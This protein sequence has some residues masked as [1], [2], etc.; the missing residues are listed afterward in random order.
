MV[1]ENFINECKKS[2]FKNRLGKIELEGYE[3]P[4]TENNYLKKFSINS[5]CYIDGTII[6]S[7][8]ISKLTGELVGLPND[9][10]LIDKTLQVQA[11]LKY[12][13]SSV[14]YVELGKYY[15]EKPKDLITC[16]QSE[17]TA[18]SSLIN[19]IDKKYICN[20]NFN[21]NV[22]VLD[23][24]KDVCS[25]LGL[26]SNCIDFINNEI[27]IFSNPFTNNETNRVVL[28]TIAIISCSFVT[29]DELTGE[30]CL[31]WLSENEEPDYIFELKD[32]STLEGGNNVFGPVNSLILKNSQINDEN[33]SIQDDESIN[34]NG[35]YPITISEDY[36]LY[37]SELRESA[38][39][40]IFNRLKGLKYV[41]YKLLSYYGKPFLKIGNKVRV[42]QDNEN[43]FDSYIFEHTFTYDGTFE[44]T[45][46]SSILTQQEIKTKQDVSLGQA[47]RNTQIEVNKQEGKIKSTIEEVNNNSSK[48][49]QV[50]QDVNSVKNMFQVTGGNNLIK[51]SQLLFGDDVWIYE[52]TDISKY[53]GG[54]DVDLVGKTVSTAKIG[55]SQGKMTSSLNNISGLVIGSQY[56]LSYKISNDENTTTIVRLIGNDVIYEKIIDA[57]CDYIEE[58]F[59][60]VS[61][62]SSYVLE[63]ETSSIYDGYCYIYDLMLNKGDKVSWEPASGEIV[64]T[65]LKL[66]RLGLQ[67]YCTGS[68]IA[69]LMTAQG[70]QVRRFANGN[71][72]EIVTEFT[73]DG[74]I[75]KKGQ[76]DEMLVKTYDMKTINYQG[77]ETLIFYK[78]DGGI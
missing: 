11:G 65:I 3:N 4:I 51:D 45:I 62:T 69:T 22:T 37:N 44:S 58:I 39:E 6:G 5:G 34:E 67:I 14:E 10:S 47:L 40:K 15:I 1:S 78:S 8:Y 50:E 36:I 43:Y 54:Y 9:M 63:I 74:F 46:S 77:Y 72:Y 19:N 68:E 16:K 31:S 13:D 52:E 25:Q 21:D 71:L 12:E 24:F 18:Y 27:P 33:V 17:F 73:K 7:I 60:F 35:E 76:L 57:K 30:L 48:I 49:S 53:E 61:T 56:T 41:D 2:A 28:Q 29:I 20:L 32:Y 26:F 75:S 23:L 70:F 55:I 66:S 42:Y 38:I 59:S 64:N